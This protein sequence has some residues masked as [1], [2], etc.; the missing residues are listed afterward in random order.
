MSVVFNMSAVSVLPVRV[1]ADGSQ[2]THA[3]A[4]ADTDAFILDGDYPGF[5]G[6]HPQDGWF[7]AVIRDTTRK[8]IIK[9][10]IAG[11]SPAAGLQVERGQQGTQAVNW[12]P[13]AAIYQDI[14]ASDLDNMLQKEVFRTIDYIPDGVLVPDYRGEKVYQSDLQLW[15]KAVDGVNTYWRL[16]AGTIGTAAPTFSNPAGSY[17]PGAVVELSTTTPGATIYYTTDGSTP[18]DASTEYTGAITLGTFTLRAIAYGPE[19]YYTPSSVASAAYLIYL[20]ETATPVLSRAA[21]A[22]ASGTTVEITCA[23]SGSTIYYTTDGSDPTSTDTEYSG[24]IAIT[25]DFTLKAIA[26]GLDGFYAPSEIVSAAYTILVE[27]ID[28]AATINGGSYNHTQLAYPGITHE[29][30]LMCYG[31]ASGIASASMV[32]DAG[33]ISISRNGTTDGDYTIQT[34]RDVNNKTAHIDGDCVIKVLFDSIT[35]PAG[36]EYGGRFV[37]TFRPAGSAVNSTVIGC[38]FRLDR[39]VGSSYINTTLLDLSLSGNT[40][41]MPSIAHLVSAMVF[42]ITITG[43]NIKV[44]Y[45][46][47]DITYTTA[48]DVSRSITGLQGWLD[49]GE[50]LRYG[51]YV[52]T[53]YGIDITPTI[54]PTSAFILS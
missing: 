4:A 25:D 22:Y 37:V 39:M 10:N 41:K 44:E 46:E 52:N 45:S 11:S 24:P 40:T 30:V 28:L 51:D 18:T 47:D 13:G 50:Y 35:V 26:Y 19:R 54:T 9:V 48:H 2:L 23:T 32:L 29:D 38:T 33:T 17:P 36:E 27:V 15:W 6:N 8:E 20:Y 31:P 1:Q 43:D 12:Q 14:T 53:S 34:Y 7:H 3:L 42:K 49:F 5:I 21:G 16:I